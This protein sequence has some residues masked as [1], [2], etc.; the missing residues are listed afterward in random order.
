MPQP[1]VVIDPGHGGRESNGGSSPYGARGPYG[2]HEKDVTLALAQRLAGRLGGF[3]QTVLTRNGDTNPSLEH[4]SRSASEHAAD[5]FLSLHVNSGPDSARGSEIYIH[6]QSNEHC[7][8]L[9]GNVSQALSAHGLQQQVL[10]RAPMAVLRP[11]ALGSKAA[12]CLVEVDYLS[13][14]DAERRLGNPRELDALADQLSR[15]IR[16]YIQQHRAGGRRAVGRP[17]G[18]RYGDGFDDEKELTTYLQDERADDT[19]RIS[20]VADA[21]QLVSDYL[22]RGAVSVWPNL[23]AKA[24]AQQIND[25]CADYRLFQQGNLNL[26]GPAA[27]LSIW[28]GRDP[29]AYA[30]Y[31]LGLL[32]R[33]TG[34]IGTHAVQA[35]DT[36]EALRYP[37]F[38]RSG[39]MTTP[40]A[41]FLCMAPLRNSAN[42]ILP[43]DP[44]SSIED[45]EGLTR[46][47]EVADWLRWTGA[48][49]TVKDEGNW[50]RSAG[51]DHAL[52]LM[53]G[54][55]IDTAVLINAN[56][57]LA[58]GHIE[59]IGDGQDP[60]LN[61]PS[62]NLI[63]SMFPN[64]FVVL[65]SELG[66]DQAKNTVS[67]RAWTWGGSYL[68]ADIPVRKFSENYYGAIKAFLRS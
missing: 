48:F 57:L 61:I 4:R 47:G 56:A 36:L 43:Y 62:S 32:E 37:R 51:I 67:L 35:K 7:Q 13:N 33:G 31:A 15:G 9:A 5:V 24:A 40:E 27:F 66:Q 18:R 64:H 39:S 45:A 55:G 12:A 46:P 11:S 65:L 21:Q 19:R 22:N 63:L 28:A 53:A 6:E 1:V 52:D 41:D 44:S 26:C 25:R 10:R 29:C 34:A 49:S 2:T 42:A 50:V 68:F 58:A 20:T 54:S 23:D 59:N 16:S 60:H 8:A 30:A 14:P 38:G 17:S 3:A